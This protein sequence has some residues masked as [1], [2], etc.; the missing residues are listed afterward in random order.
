MANNCF[1]VHGDKGNNRVCLLTQGIDKISLGWC[2]KR[3]SI[4]RMYGRPMFFFF[5]SNQ[6]IAS[7]N[8]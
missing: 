3:R 4:H 1:G 8:V 7:Q 2:F 5:V 6:H